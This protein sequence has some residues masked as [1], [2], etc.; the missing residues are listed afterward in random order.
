MAPR[1]LPKAWPELATASSIQIIGAP[2]GLPKAW[3]EQATTSSNAKKEGGAHENARP[4][5]MVHPNSWFSAPGSQKTSFV[6]RKIA[7][8]PKCHKL[9]SSMMARFIWQGQAVFK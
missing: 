6:R 9:W 1:E 5:T 4:R 7:F 2:R 8:F 3:P